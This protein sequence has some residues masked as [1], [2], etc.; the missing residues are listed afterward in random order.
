MDRPRWL[1][2]LGGGPGPAARPVWRPLAAVAALVLVVFGASLL[3]FPAV[4]ETVADWLG[5]RGIGI[6][7]VPSLQPIPTTYRSLGFGRPATLDEARATVE[8]AILLPSDPQLGPPDE[9]YLDQS[10][11]GGAVSLVWAARPGIPVSSTTGAGLVLTEFRASINQQFL[12]KVVGPRTTI[13]PVHVDGNIDYWISGAPHE[14]FVVG[15]SGQPIPA[16]I[17][18]SGNVLMWEDGELTLRFEG[19]LTREDAL[20]LAD[21]VR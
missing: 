18:L 3:A 5:L 9:V 19:E 17:R 16:T 10:L 2:R 15:P 8:W 11:P 4:R 20:R 21:S 14:V 7:V 12:Q 1:G 6:S 13:E